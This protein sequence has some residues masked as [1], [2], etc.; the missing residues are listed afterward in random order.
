[1]VHPQRTDPD[2]GRPRQVEN[3]DWAGAILSFAGGVPGLVETSRVATG[4]KMDIAFEITG[5]T[6]SL[7]FSGEDYNALSVCLPEDGEPACRVSARS[8]SMPPIPPM[9]PSSPHR[10]T[11]WASTTEDH[12]DGGFPQGDPHGPAARAGS[13]G[14]PCIGRLCEAIIASSRSGR[15]IDE[16]ERADATLFAKAGG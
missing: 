13:G 12:R 4:R 1:M 2:T 5:E 14:S 7:S 16:P 11:D 9:A 3:E 8:S 10:R 6:G 15:R